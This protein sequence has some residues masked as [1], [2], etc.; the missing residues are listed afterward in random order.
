[1]SSAGRR[2]SLRPGRSSITGRVR[3]AVMTAMAWSRVRD[4]DGRPGWPL[5]VSARV[6]TLRLIR[7]LASACRMARLSARCPMLTAAVEYP[8]GHGGQ[9]LPDVGGRE[10]AEFAGA[11]H[12]QD[13]LEHV[14][15]LRDRFGGATLETVGEPVLGGLPERVVGVAGL[16][17]GALVELVVQVAELVDDG[18]FGGA[19]DLAAGALAVAGV[20]GGEFAAPQARAVAVAVRVAAGA[21]V[22]EGDAVFAVPAPGRHGA[23]IPRG[24]DI[25]W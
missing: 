10:V 8:A 17:G 19:A 9:G 24:G 3:A 1:M 13:R 18:G 21:A 6:A 12:G 16:R 25:Q 4:L 20:A 2:T 14:L 22:F 7:S 15:V 11:D 23:G 5:G